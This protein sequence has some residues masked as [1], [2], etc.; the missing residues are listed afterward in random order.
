LPCTRSAAPFE[1]RNI[2]E[3]RIKAGV[4]DISKAEI[5]SQGSAIENKAAIA[6][7]SG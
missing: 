2:P 3:A 5:L 6:G 1:P 7:R 4:I